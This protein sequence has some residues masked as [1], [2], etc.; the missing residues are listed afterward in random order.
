[1]SWKRDRYPSDDEVVEFVRKRLRVSSMDLARLAQSGPTGAAQDWARRKL[2][3]LEE[4]GRI[5]S[6]RKLSDLRLKL[7]IPCT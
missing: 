4:A 1:M 7:Y 2:R 5:S 3:A 6:E